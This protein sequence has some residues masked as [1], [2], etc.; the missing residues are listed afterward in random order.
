MKIL[1]YN[2]I[3]EG[4]FVHTVLFDL[5]CL[6]ILKINQNFRSNANN[7]CVYK[8][9]LPISNSCV[10]QATRNVIIG[11]FDIFNLHLRMVALG[12]ERCTVVIVRKI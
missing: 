4:F 6:Q 11:I 5:G 9:Q 2:Y 10:S 8:W 7:F 1:L 3:A 12:T